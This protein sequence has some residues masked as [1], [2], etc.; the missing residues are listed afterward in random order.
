M[1]ELNLS[2]GLLHSSVYSPSTC[3][4]HHW[5]GHWPTLSDRALSGSAPSLVPLKAPSWPSALATCTMPV[6][7]QLTDQSQRT[8]TDAK[9]RKSA[10]EQIEN[11]YEQ[12][13]PLNELFKQSV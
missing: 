4:A 5:I 13:R 8:T 9:Q 6:A 7:D 2:E 10:E 12:N 11:C 3:V 1:I